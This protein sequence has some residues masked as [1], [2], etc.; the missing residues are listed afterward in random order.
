MLADVALDSPFDFRSQA[1]LCIPTDICAP[2]EK[3]FLDE[4]VNHVREVLR[5]THGHAFVLSHRST[6]ST[7]LTGVLKR[8]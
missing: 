7:S 2:D 1:M 8:N 3:G 5:I 6:P 4:V